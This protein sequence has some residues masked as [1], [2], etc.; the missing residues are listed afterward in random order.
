MSIEPRPEP[1]VNLNRLMPAIRTTQSRSLIMTSVLHFVT[2]SE[3]AKC[4]D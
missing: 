1:E 4:G 3:Q 2:T